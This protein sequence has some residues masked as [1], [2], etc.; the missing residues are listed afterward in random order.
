MAVAAAATVLGAVGGGF[1]DA[2]DVMKK[3][4]VLGRCAHGRR[5]TPLASKSQ[6]GIGGA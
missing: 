4:T 1:A 6:T 5:F 2:I 3:V